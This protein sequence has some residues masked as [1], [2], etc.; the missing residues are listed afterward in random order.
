MKRRAT[1]PKMT[2]ESAQS[3][4]RFSIHNATLVKASL[5]CDCDPYA[6]VFTFKRWKAQGRVVMRGQHGIRIG[7]VLDKDRD[8]TDRPMFARASVFCRCQTAPL[9]PKAGS[10]VTTA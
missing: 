8:D 4:G 3:F 1:R 7:V 6:D 10:A 2:A 5:T 9:E